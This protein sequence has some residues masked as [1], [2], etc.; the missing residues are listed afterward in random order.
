ME[1]LSL[2]SK[3]LTTATG[4]N[5]LKIVVVVVVVVVWYK[6]IVRLGRSGHMILRVT[7]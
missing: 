4:K 5:G 3:R 1:A 7:L 2:G 6:N